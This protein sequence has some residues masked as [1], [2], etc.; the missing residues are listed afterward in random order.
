MNSDTAASPK[1]Y[2]HI[3]WLASGEL[4]WERH[5][6]RTQAEEAAERLSRP[7]ERYVVELFE[8]SCVKCATLVRD[9]KS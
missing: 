6:T 4:D 9:P 3:R 2:Y 5:D 1:I 8:E 7:A